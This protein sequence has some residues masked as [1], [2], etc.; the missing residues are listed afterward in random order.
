MWQS[1]VWCVSTVSISEYFLK[2][3]L[4]RYHCHLLR[5]CSSGLHV[6]SLLIVVEL[7]L[8]KQKHDYSYKEMD[9]EYLFMTVT[10]TKFQRLLLLKHFYIDLITYGYKITARDCRNPIYAFFNS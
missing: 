1:G 6:I 8:Q 10:V 2:Q 7:L 4:L 9:K 3:F 5:R